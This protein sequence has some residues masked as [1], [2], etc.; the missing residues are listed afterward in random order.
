M[1]NSNLKLS[2]NCLKVVGFD[3]SLRNWGIAA[4]KL[5]LGDT[6]HLEIAT[7][8][9]VQPALPNGKQIRQNSLDL[10]SAH[11]LAVEAFKFIEE[12]DAVFVEVPV[13]SQSA[14][15]MASYGICV[16]ILG[17]LKA[18]GVPFFELSPEE[19]KRASVG[20]KTASKTQMIEWAVA[21]YPQAPWPVQKQKGITSIVAGKAEH[22]AD[23]IATIQ[24]GIT[25]LPFQQLLALLKAK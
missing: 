10:T 6:N 23:A 16:G 7:I 12:A 11:L 24:A 3:P 20:I 18:H 21:N 2:T 25:C 13:G 8:E 17:A 22:M 14:R 5:Y 9:V 19:V 15:A 1:L 4:G